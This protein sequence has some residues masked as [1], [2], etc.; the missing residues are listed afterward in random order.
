MSKVGITK[1]FKYAY[2]GIRVVEIEADSELDAD[3]EAAIFA[4]DNKLGKKVA[5]PRKAKEE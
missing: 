2:E 1:S 3:D 4:I 5:E